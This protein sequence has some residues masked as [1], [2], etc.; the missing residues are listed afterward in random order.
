MKADKNATTKASGN[1]QG[2]GYVALQWE[3]RKDFLLLSFLP[4]S[5]ASSVVT[6][7]LRL[8]CST[9]FGF[10]HRANRG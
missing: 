7:A 9:Q 10:D 5:T 4:G 8:R 6:A 3:R 2:S 1:D